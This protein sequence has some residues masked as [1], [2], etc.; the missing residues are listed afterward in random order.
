MRSRMVLTSACSH[1][2]T[3]QSVF[4]DAQ[5]LTC[6]RTDVCATYA[7]LS[8]YGGSGIYTDAASF[9]VYSPSLA[10]PAVVH[11]FDRIRKLVRLTRLRS[12]AATPHHASRPSIRS[13]ATYCPLLY[14][15]SD[16]CIG[17][18]GRRC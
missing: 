18:I 10:L 15:T 9:L 11:Q 5:I 2:R 14:T 12:H 8:R 4:P 17:A 1:A 6:A 3:P 16:G 13:A 7:Q